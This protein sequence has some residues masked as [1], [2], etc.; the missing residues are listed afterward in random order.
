M[1]RRAQR[2]AILLFWPTRASFCHHSSRGV[3][4]GRLVRIVSK[5]AGGFMGWPAPPAPSRYAGGVTTRERSGAM[6]IAV[7]GLDLGKNSCSVA[8][9]D[10]TGRVVLRRRV[11]RDGVVRL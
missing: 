3:P 1:P 6:P 10:E 4:F 11:S 8:G 7:L 9:L 5:V 2:R